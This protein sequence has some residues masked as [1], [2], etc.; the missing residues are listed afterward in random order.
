MSNRDQLPEPKTFEPAEMYL[1]NEDGSDQRRLTHTDWNETAPDW[2][3][4]GTMIAF[5]GNKFCAAPWTQPCNKTGLFLMNPSE[6]AEQTLLTN[7]APEEV[8][9]QLGVHFGAWS[10]DGQRI[11]FNSWANADGTGI[12][13]PRT[14]D[15]FFIKV[16]GTGLTNLTQNI[17]N[18]TTDILADDFRPDWYGGKIVFT[19]NRDGNLEIYIMN[20]D[21]S[22]QTRLTNNT[23][24]DR[25]PKWSPDGTKIAF[26][27]VR[28]GN[29]EIYVMNADGTGLD[30]LT[31]TPAEEA[32]VS[33][34]PNGR[35]IAFN[36]MVLAEG[37]VA[38]HFQIF[39]M[40]ADGSHQEQ[41]TVP[42][43]P[44]EINAFPSWGQTP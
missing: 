18:G 23:A 14:R 44:E 36:R 16:D 3:P 4:D 24:S 34:S 20:A 7:L 9:V 12:Q 19:T 26:E 35:K 11:A 15:I 17:K 43:Y 21:G 25:G 8:G 22:G 5:H 38:P 37:A 33:W 28:D 41:L 31:A 1:M 27:S 39:T 29:W 2:S 42:L 40:K 10:S 32:N 6:P 30:R 13:P